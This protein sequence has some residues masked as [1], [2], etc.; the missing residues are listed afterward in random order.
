MPA[1]ARATIVRGTTSTPAP[2][3]APAPARDD[4]RFA[5]CTAGKAAGY[6]PYRKGVDPGAAWYRDGDGDGDGI[7]CE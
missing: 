7:V 6:G 3:P 5:T 2:A 1:P 4:P